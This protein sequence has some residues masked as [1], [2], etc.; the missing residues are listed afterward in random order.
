MQHIKGIL[1]A[2][3]IDRTPRVALVV[4]DNLEHS[5]TFALPRLCVGMLTA[6]LSD[7][8]RDTDMILNRI[9]ESHQILLCRPTQYSGFSP[10]TALPRAIYPRFR[11][12]R[13]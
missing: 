10:G 4:F 13:R 1:E 5:R 8:E 11:I 7:T 9:R 6:E 3:R 2:N 12:Q